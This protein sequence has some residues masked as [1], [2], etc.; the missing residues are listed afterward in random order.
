MVD[1]ELSRLE[2]IERSAR[3]LLRLTQPGA[4][5]DQALLNAATELWEEAV[6]AVRTPQEQPPVVGETLSAPLAR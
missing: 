2:D 1:P 5:A 4:F 6:A 3:A